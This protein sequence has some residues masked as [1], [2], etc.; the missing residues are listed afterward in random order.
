[1][2]KINSTQLP[3]HHCCL[4]QD[5][6]VMTPLQISHWLRL[7]C[8]LVPRS[9]IVILTLIYVVHN[10]QSVISPSLHSVLCV[11]WSN[12]QSF[13][14]CTKAFPPK[15]TCTVMRAVNL[16][17][18]LICAEQSCRKQFNS[19][20]TLMLFLQPHCKM[21]CGMV[22]GRCKRHAVLTYHMFQQ[23]SRKKQRWGRRT[24]RLSQIRKLNNKT[25][26]VTASQKVMSIYNQF[27][28]NHTHVASTA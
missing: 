8:V 20:T 23:R 17:A 1:M 16:K 19:W 27:S 11:Q 21:S 12:I 18:L 24:R 5:A 7:R 3:Q 22:G 26:L 2:L 9:V 25:K 4:Y 15:N 13:F 14:C 10:E 28:Q 6:Y